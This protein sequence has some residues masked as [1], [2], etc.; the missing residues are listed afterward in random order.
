MSLKIIIGSYGTP[1][2]PHHGAS[3]GV[4]LRN[5]ERAERFAHL[6]ALIRPRLPGYKSPDACGLWPGSPHRI[7]G[8]EIEGDELKGWLI[9]TCE[10]VEEMRR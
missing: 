8:V 5:R 6:A 4:S 7:V 3:G 10:P 1:W 9:A 2:L